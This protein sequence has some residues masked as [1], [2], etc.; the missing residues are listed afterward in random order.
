LSDQL[1]SQTA[2]AGAIGYDKRQ[3]SFWLASPERPGS[4]NLSSRIARLIEAKFGKTHGWLDGVDS[5]VDVD[6][7]STT[8][9]AAMELLAELDKIREHGAVLTGNPDAITVAYNHLIRRHG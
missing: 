7:N 1:G 5:V 4:K 3:V 8:M 2:L 9:R 6:A